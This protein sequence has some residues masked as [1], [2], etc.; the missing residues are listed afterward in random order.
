MREQTRARTA[1]AAGAAG[2]MHQT[3]GRLQSLAD[4]HRAYSSAAHGAGVDNE[5]WNDDSEMSQ[6]NRLARLLF[7][8]QANPNE[9]HPGG[10]AASRDSGVSLNDMEFGLAVSNSAQIQAGGDEQVAANLILDGAVTYGAGAACR[11]RW[12]AIVPP[13]RRAPLTR[14]S[15]IVNLR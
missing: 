4:L 5:G 9:F 10:G 3:V 11:L 1:N 15:A 14:P 13:S 12:P 7:R 2:I 6:N 8:Y